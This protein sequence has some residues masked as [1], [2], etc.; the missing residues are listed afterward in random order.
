MRG[1]DKL[2]AHC[3]A[4][5][6]VAEDIANSRNPITVTIR[7]THYGHE[8]SLGHIRLQYSHRQAIAGKPVQG[9]ETQHIIDSIWENVQDK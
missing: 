6:T 2:N 1:S 9:V 8:C 3:T 5:I 4:S 7:K